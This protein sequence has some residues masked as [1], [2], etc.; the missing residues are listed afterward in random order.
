MRVSNRFVLGVTLL[1]LFSWACNAGSGQQATVQ[2]LGDSISGTATAGAETGLSAEGM[3]QTAEAVATTQ[4]DSLQGTAEAELGVSADQGTATAEAAAPLLERLP[5]YGVDPNAG[6]LAWVHPPVTVDVSGYL[7]SDFENQFFGTVA[8]DFVM[9]S[10][11]TWNTTTGLSGCG[12]VFR[13]DADEEAPSQYLALISRGGNGRVV[14]QRMFD[15]EVKTGIDMYASDKDPFFEWRNDTTNRLT[16]VARGDTFSFYTNGNLIDEL[17]AD[18]PPTP[19]A[20]PIPPEEPPEDAPPEAADEY[21]VAREEYEEQVNRLQAR[22][23]AERRAHQEGLPYLDRGFV[24]MIAV[25]ESG[26]T[27]CQFEDAWLWRFDDQ[28]SVGGS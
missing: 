17:K 26:R 1:V 27:V 3:V 4:L 7:Q 19:P 5:D 21:E 22:Y 25:S 8:Q 28:V 18:D 11:I 14:Y 2:A 9:S 6:Q 24:A 16:L 10:E 23:Q 20:L 13:S 15:G 12:F